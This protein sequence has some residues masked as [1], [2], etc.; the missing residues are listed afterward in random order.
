MPAK[1]Y[2]ILWQQNQ[3]VVLYPSTCTCLYNS[4][5]LI[6]QTKCDKTNQT[7]EE[8]HNCPKEMHLFIMLLPF[9]KYIQTLILHIRSN[10]KLVYK[11][12]SLQQE[13]SVIVTSLWV[14]VPQINTPK[15][16]ATESESNLWFHCEHQ[17]VFWLHLSIFRQN[18]TNS[19][20]L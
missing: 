19:E 10:T 20:D 12:K 1:I 2:S 4:S 5:H 7:T 9:Y 14:R 18:L 6:S 15:E 8:Y 16:M 13:S 11:T 3:C 17:H